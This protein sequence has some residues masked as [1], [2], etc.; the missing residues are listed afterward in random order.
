MISSIKKKS[1]M[2]TLKLQQPSNPRSS[3]M[4]AF[5]IKNLMTKK[6]KE[7]FDSIESDKIVI[8]EVE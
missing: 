5:S 1:G 4:G 7:T 2:P 6:N 8:S 3:E